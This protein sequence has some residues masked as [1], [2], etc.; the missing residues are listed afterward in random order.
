MNKT[1]AEKFD[2]SIKMMKE[3]SVKNVTLFGEVTKR[4]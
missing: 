4:V 2:K 3:M 1:E